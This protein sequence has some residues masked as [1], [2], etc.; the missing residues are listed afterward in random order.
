MSKVRQKIINHFTATGNEPV[1]FY[2]LL[3]ACAP[4]AF[5]TVN[6]WVGKMLAAEEMVEVSMREAVHIQ[7]APQF[8]EEVARELRE[9]D[10]TRPKPA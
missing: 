8:Y 9:S 7:L 4:T 3:A 6:D 1:I 10:E 5:T 2:T